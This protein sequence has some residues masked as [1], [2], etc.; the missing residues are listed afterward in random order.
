MNL[1]ALGKRGYHIPRTGTV[2]VVSKHFNLCKPS[3]LFSFIFVEVHFLH[4]GCLVSFY[5]NHVL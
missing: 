5:N 3:A 1:D 2:Q 4:K